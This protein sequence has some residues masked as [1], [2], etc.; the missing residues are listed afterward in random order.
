MGMQQVIGEADITGIGWKAAD[1][2]ARRI[3][4]TLRVPLAD[5][6]DIRQSLL[7]EL[8]RRAPRF[9]QQ[10]S[11]STFANL[12]VRHAGQEVADQLVRDYRRHGGSIDEIEDVAETDG[13]TAWWGTGTSGVSAMHLRLDIERFLE[14]LPENLQRLCH[15]LAEEDRST[16]QTLSGFS[17]SEFFR[18][19]HELRMRLRAQGITPLGRSGDSAST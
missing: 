6:A 10:A 18:Q 1:R 16:A 4:R 11:W 9:G 15:L 13:L 19:I 5:V 2:C 7:L 14:G 12:V 8:V 3:G 17:R